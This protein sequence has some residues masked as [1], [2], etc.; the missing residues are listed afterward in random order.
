MTLDQRD[1][2]LRLAIDGE[3]RLLRA[4]TR[5]HPATVDALLDPE[6]FEFGASGRRWDR[7]AMIA[8]LAQETAEPGR[9]PSA[10]DMAAIRV[11][12]GVVLLTYISADGGRLCRRSSIWRE[13]SAGWRVLFHQGTPIP[14]AATT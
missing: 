11:A 8:A 13:T 7:A 14:P 4:G 10:R 12:P 6:F 3:L 1:V 9:A 5:Q 2:D